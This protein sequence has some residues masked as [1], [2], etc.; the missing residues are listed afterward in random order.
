MTKKHNTYQLPVD[1]NPYQK[2]QRHLMDFEA[3]EEITGKIEN[4]FGRR[5]DNG[6]QTD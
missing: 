5:Q 3:I 2:E 4:K 6:Q 1:I